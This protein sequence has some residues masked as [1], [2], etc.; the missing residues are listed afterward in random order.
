MLSWSIVNETDPIIYC[1]F[2]RLGHI[3]HARASEVLITWLGQNQKKGGLTFKGRWSL[4][5]T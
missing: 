2:Y 3:G 5:P 1:I 4:T